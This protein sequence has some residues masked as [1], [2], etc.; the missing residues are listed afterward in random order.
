V[1]ISSGAELFRR[2]GYFARVSLT[3]PHFDKDGYA[4][5][6]DPAQAFFSLPSAVVSCLIGKRREGYDA[7]WLEKG[8]LDYRDFWTYAR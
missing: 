2:D 8:D 7:W 6:E 1:A 4:T 3:C 5:G